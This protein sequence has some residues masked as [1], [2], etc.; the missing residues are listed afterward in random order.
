MMFTTMISYAS[1]C[2][3]FYSDMSER[4]VIG[5]DLCSAGMACDLLIR[6]VK[7]APKIR[8]SLSENITSILVR[9]VTVWPKA[10]D[11]YDEVLAGAMGVNEMS[12]EDYFRLRKFLTLVERAV[13]R[14]EINLEEGK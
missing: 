6:G 5:N 7:N 11:G 2:E 9:L 4:H 8:K 10:G 14:R 13:A 1:S 3:K 12:E